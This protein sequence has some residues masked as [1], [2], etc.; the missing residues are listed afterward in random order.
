MVSRDQSLTITINEL[1]FSLEF[2][3]ALLAKSAKIPLI[4]ANSNTFMC[5]AIVGVFLLPT[6]CWKHQTTS[7]LEWIFLQ[8]AFATEPK[9]P[10][11]GPDLVLK[12]TNFTNSN[13]KVVQ[14]PGLVDRAAR[15][16][17]RCFAEMSFH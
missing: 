1:Q 13:L 2:F 5:A 15:S 14:R 12:Q 9:L 16:V 8:L 10:V 6:I 4:G 11:L 17:S 3:E 7:I